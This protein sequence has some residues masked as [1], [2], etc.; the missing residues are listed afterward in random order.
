MLNG[1][2]DI[3]TAGPL[4]PFIGGG[5]GLAI[6]SIEAKSGTEAIAGVGFKVRPDLTLDAAYKFFTKVGAP[7]DPFIFPIDDVDYTTHNFT[8]GVR[9][10]F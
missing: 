9:F 1:Y 10:D 2:V 4:T 3:K 7:V 8:L 6:L 5:F